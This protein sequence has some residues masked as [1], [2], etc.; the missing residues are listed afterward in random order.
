MPPPQAIIPPP[1]SQRVNYLGQT[2]GLIRDFA[3]QGDLIFV[4]EGE[5]ADRPQDERER[6]RNGPLPSES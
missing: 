1:V 5:R 2:G 4:P 3:I 6:Q